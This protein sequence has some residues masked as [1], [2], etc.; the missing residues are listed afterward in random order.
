MELLYGTTIPL[1]GIYPKKP[2][3]LIQKNIRSPLFI[4]A[5]FTIAKGWNQPKC[6]SVDG[7]VDKKAEVH[8]YNRTLVSREKNKNEILLFVMT[9]MD[10]EDIML[11]EKSQRNKN[12]VWFHLYVEP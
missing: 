1:L 2:K 9:W 7:W 3:A 12:T 10:L 5:L 11:S 6:P 4:A 8:I